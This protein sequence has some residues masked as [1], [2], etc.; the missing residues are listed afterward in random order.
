MAATSRNQS[1]GIKCSQKM[2]LRF[3]RPFCVILYLFIVA[4][5]SAN[6]GEPDT[7]GKKFTIPSDSTTDSRVEYSDVTPSLPAV[8]LNCHLNLSA[9]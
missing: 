4:D 5:K 7:A 9:L 1:D 6:A 2:F 3:T 8:M